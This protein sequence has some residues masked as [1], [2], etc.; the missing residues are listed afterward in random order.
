MR[1]VNAEQVEDVEQ[2]EGLRKKVLVGDEE[3]ENAM[4]RF[5]LEPNARVPRHTNSVEHIQYVL[6]AAIPSK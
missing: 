3:T 4:R 5:V 1:L 6:E 2:A